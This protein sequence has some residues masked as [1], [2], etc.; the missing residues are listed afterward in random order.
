MTRNR[1]THPAAP[2]VATRISWN[3]TTFAASY[4]RS[5]P[6]DRRRV[7]IYLAEPGRQAL[8][9][10]DEALLEHAG[11]LFADFNA[12]ERE[13]LAQVLQRLLAAHSS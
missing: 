8:D 12:A 13:H 5:D 7:L 6:F 11:P 9:Q 3:H 4:R 10:V 1:A 2:P